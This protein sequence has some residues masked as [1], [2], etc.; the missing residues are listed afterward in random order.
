LNFNRA[1]TESSKK[2]MNLVVS[3]IVASFSLALN[4]LRRAYAVAQPA[5]AEL[6]SSTAQ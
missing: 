5:V 4:D 3:S 6:Y 1:I 2:Q